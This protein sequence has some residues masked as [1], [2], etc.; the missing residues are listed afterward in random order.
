M[1]EHL[2]DDDAISFSGFDGSAEKMFE[3]ELDT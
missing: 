3:S 2:R 1:L